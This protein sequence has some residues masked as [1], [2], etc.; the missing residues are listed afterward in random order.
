MIKEFYLTLSN[1][2]PNFYRSLFHAKISKLNYNA[3]INYPLSDYGK[4]FI[5]R[6]INKVVIAYIFQHFCPRFIII[7]G[8]KA[9][10]DFIAIKRGICRLQKGY[11][12]AHIR[13]LEKAKRSRAAINSVSCLFIKNLNLFNV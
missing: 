11:K 8:K 6:Y 10:T 9:T 4:G 5:N 12:N 2:K 1:K 3:I 13:F 7:F